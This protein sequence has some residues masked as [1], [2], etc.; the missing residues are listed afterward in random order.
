[1]ASYSDDFSVVFG[2]RWTNYNSNIDKYASGDSV[3]Q[4]SSTDASW[5]WTRYSSAMAS[6]NHYAQIECTWVS[7]SFYSWLTP[8]VRA[9]V[10]S[11]RT[12]YAWIYRGS[13][14]NA[15]Y[16]WNGSTNLL[17]ASG[18]TASNPVGNTFKIS[19]E[20][21]FIRTYVNGT[22]SIEY[23]D[24]SWASRL[25]SYVGLSG[26]F[27]VWSRGDNFLAEDLGG[28]AVTLSDITYNARTA[29][30]ITPRV[31]ITYS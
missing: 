22:L 12:G 21:A 16:Y 31:D 5:A 7:D 19:A 29:T 18:G 6:S 27:N 28:G 25:N 17:L 23:E 9:T 10:S 26:H 8:L 4:Q 13:G 14:I 11:D 30:S 15:L 2:T 20:N 1:M 3:Y 24:T